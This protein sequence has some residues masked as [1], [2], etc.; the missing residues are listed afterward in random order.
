MSGDGRN[1][2]VLVAVADTL[3]AAG[4]RH[5][6]AHNLG[7]DVLVA[8]DLDDVSPLADNVDYIITD[9]EML[10]RHLDY[11]LPRRDKVVLL[12]S[13]DNRAPHGMK[14]LNRN[15]DEAQLTDALER[16]M[17][18]GRRVT[19]EKRNEL[20]LREIDVLRLVAQG[21]TNKE[22]ADALSISVN[23][24]LTHRKNISGKL[25][26][27]SVSGLGFYALMNGIVTAA[28]RH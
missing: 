10:A 17:Q 11:F 2:R 23:T 18:A 16:L 7:H 4:L 1:I 25:G 3:T 26:I 5:L 14:C 12:T 8:G 6:I 19:H 20:S 27:K 15:A 28:P 21:H 24:V 9:A 13:A 22:I